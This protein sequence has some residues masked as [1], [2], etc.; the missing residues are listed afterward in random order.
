MHSKELL[1]FIPRYAKA[2]PLLQWELNRQSKRYEA[3]RGR[4][5]DFS[6]AYW[7][8][9][10]PGREAFEVEQRQIEDLGLGAMVS[11]T[12]HDNIDAGTQLQVALDRNVP[13]SVEWT[14]PIGTTYFHLGVHNLP[15][16]S[17]HDTMA[18]LAAYTAKPDRKLLRDLMAELHREP[19]SL[20]VLN[21]PLWD[22]ATI[23]VDRHRA[24]LLELLGDTGQWIDAVELNGL[25]P[26]REN[27]GVVTFARELGLTLVSGGDRHGRE[28]NAVINLTNAASFAEFAEEVRSGASEILFMP[29]Y[30]EPFR[31]RIL[32][33]LREI[34]RDAPDLV[35]RERWTDRVFFSPNGVDTI[36]L[37]AGWKG[38]GPPV[39]R[40]FVRGVCFA[41]SDRVQ[42][43]LRPLMQKNFEFA[44]RRG[45]V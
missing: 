11:L 28:P 5:V 27:R 19:D 14:I 4:P 33:G 39:V 2:I 13:I 45:V 23:G 21:H 6:T 42:R 43:A 30:R 12:D 32:K 8:P 25:R 24:T 38:D 9:A 10:L 1:T 3:R 15:P 29:Q 7:T 34:L 41:G 18:A 36:P 20:I 31:L 17:A 35:G 22:Q 26:W 40:W 16:Y 44:V 37:A